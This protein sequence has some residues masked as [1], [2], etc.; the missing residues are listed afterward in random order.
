MT[1][2]TQ[3]ENQLLLLSTWS[4]VRADEF[5]GTNFDYCNFV[6]AMLFT[7]VNGSI[8][9]KMALRTKT[10]LLSCFTF[11]DSLTLLYTFLFGLTK[12]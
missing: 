3:T 12:L 8:L 5:R 1:V 2:F 4:A 10:V 11:Q 7:P 6:V 9:L